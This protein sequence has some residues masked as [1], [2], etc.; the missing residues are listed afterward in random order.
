MIDV[1]KNPIILG[2]LAS[3]ITYA[4]MYWEANR[5]YEKNPKIK[6]EQISILIPSIVGIIVWFVASGYFNNNNGNLNKTIGGNNVSNIIPYGR[7]AEQADIPQYIPT[8]NNDMNGSC[9]FYLL[10]KDRIKIPKMDVLID[11]GKFN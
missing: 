9:S 5:K 1:F 11:L 6:R 3:L 8:N 4:Y 10:Q 7:V 2:V